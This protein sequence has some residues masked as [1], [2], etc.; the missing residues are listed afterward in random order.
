MNSMYLIFGLLT[1]VVLALYAKKRKKKSSE[2]INIPFASSDS[3]EANI[4]ASSRY[5]EKPTAT[6]RIYSGKSP[7][8]TVIEVYKNDT[9]ASTHHWCAGGVTL[10]DDVLPKITF[11]YDNE[12]GGYKSKVAVKDGIPFAFN[13]PISCDKFDYIELYNE[14]DKIGT[15]FTTSKLTFK[16]NNNVTSSYFFLTLEMT[17]G[18]LD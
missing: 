11:D 6:I 16:T 3:W 9:L 12:A 10:S 7:N 1:L 8:G 17:S 13:A 14:F 5:P 15:K 2:T 18:P 4:T